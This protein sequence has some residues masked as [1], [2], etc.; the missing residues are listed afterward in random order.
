M[1]IPKLFALAGI[2]LQ[3]AGEDQWKALCP[4]HGDSSPSFWVYDDGTYH[5]FGCL[6]H[7]SIFSLSDALMSDQGYLPD[8]TSVKDDRKEMLNKLHKQLEI[9]LR[10]KLINQDPTLR[11]LL[12]DIFDL[13]FFHAQAKLNYTDKSILEVALFV[14]KKYSQILKRIVK[15]SVRK[16]VF[17]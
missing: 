6:A 12:Y 1:S 13:T 10:K 17:S 3:P 15:L 8:I 14:R 7:G 2:K 4:F 5:C 11:C 16:I 9:D